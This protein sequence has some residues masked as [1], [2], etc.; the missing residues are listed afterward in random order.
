MCL[1]NNIEKE[2]KYRS[3]SLSNETEKAAENGTIFSMNIQDSI[4]KSPFYPYITDSNSSSFNDEF[5][6]DQ[7]DFYPT[8]NRAVN[9]Q[10]VSGRLCQQQINPSILHVEPQ[11]M[12]MIENV[13][14]D[15][16]TTK[17]YFAGSVIPNTLVVSF[18][19]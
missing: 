18:S 19:I 14:L 1:G 13:N 12:K 11:T 3:V 5:R 9:S 7:A 10:S 6:S 2:Q 8:R 15:N 4:E 17:S 16:E